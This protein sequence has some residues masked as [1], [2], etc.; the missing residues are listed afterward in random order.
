MDFKKLMNFSKEQKIALAGALGF[1]VLFPI[2]MYVIGK[3]TIKKYKP[4]K[5]SIS[6]DLEQEVNHL[7]S[8]FNLDSINVF[9]IKN[10]RVA[11]NKKDNKE[12]DCVIFRKDVVNSDIAYILTYE[13]NKVQLLVEVKTNKDK[14]NED[15][16]MAELESIIKQDLLDLESKLS[17]VK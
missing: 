3:N 17:E 2:T 11:L 15:Y 4:S 6:S 13:D 9:S 14:S 10:E 7:F 8:T 16:D 12:L 1:A 5:E